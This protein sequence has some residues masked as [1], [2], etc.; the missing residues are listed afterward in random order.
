[1]IST[2]SI[3]QEIT[4]TAQHHIPGDLII[5]SLHF[6]DIESSN[7]KLLFERFCAEISKSAHRGR[8][9]R[10]DRLFSMNPFHTRQII[11]ERP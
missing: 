11:V 4:C 7:L 6:D 9:K 5:P 8:E 2:Q 3:H 1:M 10:R